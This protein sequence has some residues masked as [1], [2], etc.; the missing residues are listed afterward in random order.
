MLT[1]DGMAKVEDEACEYYINKYIKPRTIT[2]EVLRGDVPKWVDVDRYYMVPGK[3]EISGKKIKERLIDQIWDVFTVDYPKSQGVSQVSD[4]ARDEELQ[5]HD[6][7]FD[8]CIDILF[9]ADDYWFGE[10][11]PEWCDAY[12]EENAEIE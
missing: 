3:C 7:Y 9:E 6:S 8:F 1:K 12:F 10:I 4:L 5:D 11:Y 2:D